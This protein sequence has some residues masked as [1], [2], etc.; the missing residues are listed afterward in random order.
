MVCG[1]PS[2]SLRILYHHRTQG[3]GAEGNH[4]A[5]IV[6]AMRSLGHHVDVLSPPGVDPFDSK[7]TIPTDQANEVQSGW[8]GLWKFFSNKLPGPLFELAELFYNL[9]AYIRLRSALSR[10]DYDLL[11]ERYAFYMFAGAFAAKGAG[12]RLVLEINEVNGVADR[13]R[14]QHFTWICSVIEKWLLRRCDLA[15]AVS[16]NLAERVAER[17]VSERRIV[18]VPNGFDVERITFNQT[19]EYMREKFDFN[20]CVVIGFAGWFVPWDRLDLLVDVFGELCGQHSNLRMCLVGDGQAARDVLDRLESPAVAES[21]VITGA[22][23]LTNVYDH[24]QMFDIGVLPHSNRFGSPMAMFE[25]MGLKVPIVA[26][27]LPPIE[28]VLVHQETAM[29]FN[30]LDKQEL[31]SCVSKLIAAPQLRQ[32]LAENAFSALKAQHSWANTAAKILSAIP[33]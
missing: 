19:R 22:I 5:S 27:R 16:S 3:R 30:A 9:P 20:D 21:I 24:M 8:S 11:F 17:G 29:L 10:R 25:M 15:H 1:M 7:A 28:D 26:P 18:I 14:K 31:G 32:N 2:L 12:C 13:V 4:I 23:P 33:D 6:G